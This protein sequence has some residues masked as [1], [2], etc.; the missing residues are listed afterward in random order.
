MSLVIGVVGH[1][2]E[3]L[4]GYKPHPMHGRIIHD[5]TSKIKE[6][7]PDYVVTGMDQG[8]GQ[9]AA[10]VCQTLKIPFVA[11]IPHMGFED[12]WPEFARVKYRNLLQQ[13]FSTFVISPTPYQ[14]GVYSAR[15][16]WVVDSSQAIVAVFDGSEGNTSN[17][18]A[19]AEVRGLPIHRI[20]PGQ[21]QEAVSEAG[22]VRRALISGAVARPPVRQ[23]VLAKKPTAEHE[24]KIFNRSVEID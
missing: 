6:L 14:P 10:Q 1:K 21:Y 11:A 2:P 9:W 17:C 24:E 16:K 20:F 3:K 15:N 13:A 8:V 4:G 23:T 19:Q 12:R 5:L 18:V 7:K 22:A